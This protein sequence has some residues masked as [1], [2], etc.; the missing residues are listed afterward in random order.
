VTCTNLKKPF[1]YGVNLNITGLPKQELDFI[2]LGHKI[3]SFN[4][5][6]SANLTAAAKLTCYGNC[7]ISPNITIPYAGATAKVLTYN[8][9]LTEGQSIGALTTDYVWTDNRAAEIAKNL[10]DFDVVGL[11][12]VYIPGDNERKL[13]MIQNAASIGLKHYVIP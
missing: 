10:K 4:S 2:A 7:T 11:Q 12:E 13:K 3:Y 1:S 5:G 9:K 6:I 8:A